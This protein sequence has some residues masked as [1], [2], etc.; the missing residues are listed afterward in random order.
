MF[1]DNWK[2]NVMHILSINLEYSKFGFIR[3]G[4]N[5]KWPVFCGIIYFQKLI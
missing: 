5:K 1:S 4:Q 2:K 3:S